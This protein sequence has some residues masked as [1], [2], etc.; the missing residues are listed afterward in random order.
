M[1]RSTA[2][3]AGALALA[4]LLVGGCS[5]DG[6]DQAQAVGSGVVPGSSASVAPGAAQPADGTTG[7]NPTPAGQPADSEASPLPP[8]SRP[9]GVAAPDLSALRVG[10]ITAT[11]TKGGSGPCYGL[12]SEDGVAWSVYSKKPVP[13]AKGD[14]VQA[15]ITPG[16]TPV[17]C[18]S[19]KPATL[20]RVMIGTD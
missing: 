6:D 9:A 18:G 5:R 10:S 15:R 2:G 7:G 8:P 19:G 1:V 3:V 12:T 20:D 11:V 4:L 14:R 13:I 17:D 16:K